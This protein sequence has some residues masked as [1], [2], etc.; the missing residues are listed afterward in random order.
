MVQA[1]AQLLGTEHQEE[2][3]FGPGSAA[4]VSTEV[5]SELWCF[6]AARM[7]ACPNPD[8]SV[9]ANARWVFLLGALTNQ[10]DVVQ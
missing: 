2:H 9:S 4:Q 3:W 1:R 8:E 5:R 6:F 10:A 7:G